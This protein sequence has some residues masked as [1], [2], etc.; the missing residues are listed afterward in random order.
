MRLVETGHRDRP[1]PLTRELTD[2]APTL[3]TVRRWVAD[4]LAD[5]SDDTRDDCLLVVNELVSN[6]YDHGSGPRGIRLRRTSR[7]CLVRFEVDDAEPD[8]PTL[9]RSRLGEDRGR[10]LVIVHNLAV[11]WGVS[12]HRDGKTVWAELD[13]AT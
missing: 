10:G 5:L 11:D 12:A 8:H 1:D 13:C 7:P 2:Q 4:A 3:A 6:A 9:G